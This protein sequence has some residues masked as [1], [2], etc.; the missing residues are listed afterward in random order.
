MKKHYYDEER[1]NERVKKETKIEIPC[2]KNQ[3]VCML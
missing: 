2:M 1:K 3:T